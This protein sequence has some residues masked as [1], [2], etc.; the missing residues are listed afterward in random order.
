LLAIG[1]A[2]GRRV[3]QASDDLRGAARISRDRLECLPQ[4]RREGPRRGD[5]AD[6]ALVVVRVAPGICRSASAASDPP[7]QSM[8]AIAAKGSL[9][10]G[11][12]ARSA[13]STNCCTA[14]PASFWSERS[15]PTT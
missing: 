9:T 14:K 6:P 8:A 1:Q 13:I 12:N 2:R 15:D 5:N 4:Q 7:S 10:A 3:E 11:D